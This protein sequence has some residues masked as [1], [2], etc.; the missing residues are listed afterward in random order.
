VL[1]CAVCLSFSTHSCEQTA[2]LL[3]SLKQHTH[4]QT[5]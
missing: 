4:A 3:V 5:G 2:V 1:C